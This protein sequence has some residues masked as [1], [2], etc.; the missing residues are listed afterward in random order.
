VAGECR[1]KVDMVIAPER[2]FGCARDNA[3]VSRSCCPM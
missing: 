2:M 3:G 1:S